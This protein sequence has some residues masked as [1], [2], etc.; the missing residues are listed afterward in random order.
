MAP[1]TPAIARETLKLGVALETETR[2]GRAEQLLFFSDEWFLMA[3]APWPDYRDVEVLDQL[4]NG[5]GMLWTFYEGFKNFAKKMPV[6][7]DAPRRVAAFTGLLGAQ[8]LAPLAKRLDRIEG[9]QFD[10]LPLENSLFGRA[11]TVSGLLPGRDFQRAIEH[12]PG[13]DHYLIPGNA[14]RWEDRVFLDDLTFERLQH[15][16]PAPLDSIEGGAIELAAAATGIEAPGRE[17]EAG[18]RRTYGY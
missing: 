12:N 10:I 17:I 8:A 16:C 5:V 3:G 2:A 11:V 14:L 13:Y 9:L 7:L 4:E 15:E 1:V 6:R 18:R